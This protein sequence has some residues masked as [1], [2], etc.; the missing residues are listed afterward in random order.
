MNKLEFSPPV[1]PIEPFPVAELLKRYPVERTLDSLPAA[2]A[3][4]RWIVYDQRRLDAIPHLA[5]LPQEVRQSIR[6]AA[7][8]FPFR[9]NAYVL[10]HLIDWDR[11]P[12]DPIFRLTFPLADMLDAR[13]VDELR[14]CS[15]K[16]GDERALRELAVKIRTQ[17]NPHPAD[18]VINTPI[19]DDQR[20]S[21]I[22][23]KYPETVLFF[24]KQGQTC[25]SYC[26]F[27][28][29]WAQFVDG[30]A[31]KFASD[32]AASLHDYLRRMSS[33][34]DL[35]LTGGDPLVMGTRRLRAYL[36]PLTAR[37]LHHVQN[38]RIGTKSLSYWPYRFTSDDD[39]NDL[40]ALLRSLIEKGKHVTVVAH[41]N[42]WREMTT[43]AF[44]DAVDRLK[45]AGI[46]IRTQSPILRHINDDA[47]TWRRNWREQV[48]LGM[49][50]YYMFVERDTGA[51]D[52]F[53]MPLARALAIY[54]EAFSTVSG[55]ARTARGP[56]MSTG[57]GKIQVLGTIDLPQGRCFVLSF[58]QARR[59][60]WLGRPF[61]A[62]FSETATWINQLTPPP[63][64][65]AFFFE[66]EYQAIVETEQARI[67]AALH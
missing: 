3:S 66:A 61:L 9:V 18:Q 37:D 34:T 39:S 5:R 2:S 26:T 32:D 7:L 44:E 6:L 21:G 8:V 17:L 52:Y 38:I 29:R 45:R 57:P 33:V 20:L 50:P 65:S 55:I 48:R 46:V 36:E 23:H 43:E 60:E 28:F 11:A 30:Q 16:A 58:L 35:L 51:H 1:S 22:Q 63:P 19:F 40:I 12:D 59:A 64:E 13:H 10:D 15:A 49:V 27:C 62:R 14:R 54:Q 31:H 53:A 4:P 67:R 24:P 41:V 25:H 42:H 47:E 56:T